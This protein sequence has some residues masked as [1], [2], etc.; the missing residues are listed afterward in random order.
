MLSINKIIYNYM[1]NYVNLKLEQR[2]INIF[3]DNRNTGFFIWGVVSICS[4][5]ENPELSTLALDIV[6]NIKIEW[7]LSLSQTDRNKWN[8]YAYDTYLSRKDCSEEFNNINGF[9]LYGF[10]SCIDNYESYSLVWPPLIAD[11]KIETLLKEYSNLSN[12]EKKEWID[13]YDLYYRISKHDLQLC[14]HKCK[15]E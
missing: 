15:N 3:K 6:E 4:E 1:Y 12:I 10:Y 5:S 7:E 9:Q 2:K 11:K 14:V 13:A 8:K